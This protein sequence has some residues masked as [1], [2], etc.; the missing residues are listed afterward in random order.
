MNRLTQ[1]QQQSILDFYFRCG[2]EED[3]DQGRD[4]IASNPEAAKLYADLESTLTDLDHIKYDACPDNLVDLTVARLKLAAASSRTENTKLNQLL[5]KEQATFSVSTNEL[6]YK[7]QGS[8]QDADKRGFLRPIFEVLA[9]AASVALVA[10]IL[11][12]GFGAFRAHSRQVACE[13]NLGQIGAAFASFAQDNNDRFSEVKVQAGSPWWK[14]GDQGQKTQ[15]NTRYPFLLIKQGYV[16]GNVFVCKGNK[17]AYPFKHQTSD[18]NQLN[19]FPSRNNI[20]YSFMLVCDKSANPLESRRKI[21]ASDRNPVF[22]PVFKKIPCD[23]TFYQKMKE[24][25]K[26]LLNEQLKQ[27]MSSNHGERG[28]N[29]LYCDGSV[30]YIESRIVNGDDIFTVRGVDTYSGC[31]A[32]IEADDIF[33]AP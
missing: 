31:E 23:P 27:M 26:V 22:E 13:R 33:L 9:A 19:D 16:D 24:F 25:E 11:F 17:Q 20:T 18:I 12:P 32:P 3:I 7:A 8:G 15:S 14:I 10:G 2:D 29:I 21:I 30:E 28:Q 6:A 4:L 5:E 1:Q